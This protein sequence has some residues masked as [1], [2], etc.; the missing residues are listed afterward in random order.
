MS[1]VN[2]TTAP[3]NGKLPFLLQCGCVQRLTSTNIYNN[4][5]RSVTASKKSTVG[6]DPNDHWLLAL[7]QAVVSTLH[8]VYPLET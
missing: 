1:C 6:I 2:P 8:H 5:K 4:F 7:Q 3:D